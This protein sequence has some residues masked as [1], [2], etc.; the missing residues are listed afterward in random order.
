MSASFPIR[1]GCASRLG[2]N[3]NLT[4]GHGQYSEGHDH[5][6]ALRWKSSLDDVKS[7]DFEYPLG[8]Q[9]RKNHHRVHCQSLR[10]EAE[11]SNHRDC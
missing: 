6:K 10:E 11:R 4:T 1:L 5:W 2:C 8:R 3:L 7:V 9:D